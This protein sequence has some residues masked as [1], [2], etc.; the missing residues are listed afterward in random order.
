MATGPV[1]I[2][3]ITY[4]PKPGTVVLLA[5]QF[6]IVVA[7]DVDEDV[8]N[9]RAKQDEKVNYR[10][11]STPQQPG[12]DFPALTAPNIGH[13][14]SSSPD[15]AAA[16]AQF[17]SVGGMATDLSSA[18]HLA[19]SA[20]G[21]AEVTFAVDLPEPLTSESG[22]PVEVRVHATISVSE[23]LVFRYGYLGAVN[24]KEGVSAD[25][26]PI[27]LRNFAACFRHTAASEDPCPELTGIPEKPSFGDDFWDASGEVQI[28]QARVV[29]RPSQEG[30]CT[31]PPPALG[32]GFGGG[33]LAFAGAE[34]ETGGIPIA[35]GVD[36][37]ALGVGF[38]DEPTY[39]ALGGCVVFGA[40]GGLV[41]VT[42]NVYAVFVKGKNTYTFTGEELP[43]MTRPYLY[44][45]HVGVGVGGSVELDL[46]VLG[47]TK[48]GEGYV[49]YVDKPAA[50]S[51][52]AGVDVS[53]PFG[54]TYE[55]PPEAGIAFKAELG[56]AIGLSKGFPPPFVLH[57]ELDAIVKAPGGNEVKGTLKGIFADE[58][59]SGAGGIAICGSASIKALGVSLGSGTAG[60]GYHWGDSLSQLAG[61]I[62]IGGSCS[63]EWFTSFEAIKVQGQAA[64]ANRTFTVAAGTDAFD[65]HLHGITAQALLRGPG[66]T[67][68]AV[69]KF[70]PGTVYRSGGAV[71][72]VSSGG[73]GLVVIERPRPGRWRVVGVG[74]FAV[75]SGS[76]PAIKVR[77][78]G[79]GFT[80][81]LRYTLGG[82]HRS[83]VFIERAGR[84]EP[85]I[86]TATGGRGR[87]RFSIPPGRGRRQIVAAVYKGRV[88]SQTVTVAWVS[89]P[90]QRRLPKVRGIRLRRTKGGF[91]LRFRRV[92]GAQAYLVKVGL[93]DGTRE[94]F[95]TTATQ[96]AVGGIYPEVG[97][98]V[99][100]VAAGDGVYLANG[101]P[102]KARLRPFLRA[103]RK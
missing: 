47:S 63:D 40:G 102:R 69:G 41:K 98:V 93:K 3:G 65:L 52:G 45:E 9:L 81:L 61:D 21:Q 11:P 56:G 10:L 2:N 85:V 23:G 18:L 50:V 17:G 8:G 66:A 46:P 20:L 43:G 6:N 100:V 13:L 74:G 49:L 73:E 101:P 60:I 51:F 64:A 1:V 88:P 94:Q 31:P 95:R 91:T 25:L 90:R 83:A 48:V 59:A 68:I 79:R 89:P 26:G 96:L 35:P 62:H 86:G 55:Q 27:E 34:L 71:V 32:I 16:K 99:T 7:G 57:G 70:A 103:R 37:E 42:G 39:S 58:P 92:R 44:T 30:L 77:L 67:Q 22:E 38:K 80:R 29:F 4:L 28:G 87:I 24:G 76:R 82:P 54:H 72:V 14:I 97:G 75:A 19:F 12:E 5:P 84:D 33:R 53:I 15:P 78:S 36:F